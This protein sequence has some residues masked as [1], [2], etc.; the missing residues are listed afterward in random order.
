[1]AQW[2]PGLEQAGRRS[3]V[4]VLHKDESALMNWNMGDDPLAHAFAFLI[5]ILMRRDYWQNFSGA[6]W[7]DRAP[8]SDASLDRFDRESLVWGPTGPDGDAGP[9]RLSGVAGHSARSL[10]YRLW[11]FVDGYVRCF[12]L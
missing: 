11:L 8:F 3:A 12:S 4:S 1:M 10:C 9:Q 7:L 2:G 6:L 5:Q